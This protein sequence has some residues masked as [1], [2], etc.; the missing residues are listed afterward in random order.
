MA[1]VRGPKCYWNTLINLTFSGPEETPAR[2]SG[3]ASP[4][5][6]RIFLRLP[7]L[8]TEL[9]GWEYDSRNQTLRLKLAD[10]KWITLKPHEIAIRGS[11][12]MEE[13]QAL[14]EWIKG[15]I[16]QVY[17]RRD[18]IIPRFTSQAGLKV[19]EILKLLPMTDC[20]ACGYATVMAYAAVRREGRIT[21]PDCPRLGEE[22]YRGKR[23]KR[24]ACLY[25]YGWRALAEW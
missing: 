15:Q 9:G 21:L 5:L 17:E 7:Y 2:R 4:P 3:G 25:S 12:D 16:N 10:G 13:A 22:K 1:I 20:K 24:Q 14:R 11:A 8:N 19:M 18:R 6:R 23:Q